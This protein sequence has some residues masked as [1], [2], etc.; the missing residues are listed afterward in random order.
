MRAKATNLFKPKTPKQI[1]SDFK[2]KYNLPY[3]SLEET[4]KQFKELGVDARI[5]KHDQRI[6]L[7]NWKLY[8]ED[9]DTGD[10]KLIGENWTKEKIDK[11]IRSLYSLDEPKASFFAKKS[12]LGISVSLVEAIDI[13]NYLKK[14]LKKK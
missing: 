10:E 14:E 8:I 3:L 6:Q 7:F 11:T 12:K 5:N 1:S 9:E 2:K 13:L 4:Y